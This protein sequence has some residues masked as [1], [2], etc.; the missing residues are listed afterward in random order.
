M[1]GNEK[2]IAVLNKLLSDELTAINQYVVH[3]E[4]C[5]NWSYG[6]LHG[7]IHKQAMEEMHHAQW[8]I[9]RII[10]LDGLPI[11]TKLNTVKIGKTILEM[12]CNDQDA[13]ISALQAYNSAIAAA[14]EANDE[15]TVDLLTK[16]LVMEE[17]HI[18]WAEGQRAQI[19]QMGLSNYL[20][21]QVNGSVV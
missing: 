8:L 10:F 12:I 13:E 3:A 17:G 19:D 7:A 11:V 20:A 15:G 5:S 21:V 16:I 2:I 9:Q 6:K 18:D 1:T 4:M 14:H